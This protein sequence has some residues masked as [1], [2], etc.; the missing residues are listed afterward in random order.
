VRKVAILTDFIGHDPAYSL[1]AVVANQA[2]MLHMGGYEFKVLTRALFESPYPGGEIQVLDPG[3]IGSN[4]VNITAKSGSEIDILT[5]QM[6]LAL[7]DVD[8][9]FTHDL[10][11]QANLWKYHVAAWRIAKDQS[12]LRW[13]HWIHSGSSMDISGQTGRF[14]SELRGKFPHACLVVFHEEEAMRKRVAFGYEMHETV[15]IPNPINF[16]EDYDPVALE[17]IEKGDLWDADIVAVYPCRLDRG[18]QP[19]IVIEIFAELRAMGWDARVVIVDFHSTAGDKAKYRKAMKAAAAKE[20]VPLLFASDLSKDTEYHIPHK[21]VMNLFDFADVLVHPSRS[22]G[23]PL[24]VPEAAWA[25]CGLVLNFDLPMFRLWQN[26]ALLY[27]F[28]SNVDV[29]TGMPGDT[30]TEYG[31]RRAYMRHVAGGIAH[32]MQNDPVLQNHMRMRKER[33]LKAVWEKHLWPAIEAD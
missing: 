29:A 8:V 32:M 12:G 11:C 14:H 4:V 25:R 15:V 13:L 5:E 23:D 30:T 6:R 26:R 10:L 28:S 22:E 19:H 33:S 3:E 24:I 27:K 9:V 7:T 20:G 2:K 17:A 16:T 21:A 18:K 1:C 31:D